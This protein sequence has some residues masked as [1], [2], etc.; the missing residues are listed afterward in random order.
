MQLSLSSEANRLPASREIP[1]ILWNPKVHYRIHKCPQPFPIL[2]Q[3]DPVH[4]TTSHILKISLNIIVPFKTGPSKW[5][6]SLRFP[7]KSLYTPLPSTPKRYV[8]QLSNSS[9]FSHPKDIGCGVQI[10]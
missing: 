1:R 8:P 7:L 9:R 2:S 3:L 10:V 5:S 4:T 6:A